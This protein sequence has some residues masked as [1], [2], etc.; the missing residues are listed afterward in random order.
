MSDSKEGFIDLDNIRLEYRY[1]DKQSDGLPTLVFLHE[2]LGSVSMWKDFPEKLADITGLNGFVYSRQSYGKSSLLEEARDA[3]YL[4]HEALEVLPRV[5]E[6]A[7]ISKPVLVGH[8]D[9]ASIALIY[10]AA[11]HLSSP[12]ALILMAAHVF[13]ET[14]SVQSIRLAKQAYEQGNLGERLGAYHENVDNAFWRWNDI[15]L[16]ED[17]KQWNIEDSLPAIS[18]PILHVQ[19]RDDEYG[20]EAQALAIQKHCKGPVEIAMLNNCG[21]SPHRDQLVTT[22]TTMN[23]FIERIN[24]SE[25]E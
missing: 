18:S 22:L 21:H 24:F 12:K 25:T 10:A 1:I 3:N 8:S 15:W 19:G 17:F 7:K 6:K 16:H 2:G 20:S 4:H 5:L 9:G 23:T 14:L 13:N 11:S